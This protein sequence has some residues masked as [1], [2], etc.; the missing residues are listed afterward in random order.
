MINFSWYNFNA[1]ISGGIKKRMHECEK[2]EKK[3]GNLDGAKE[4]CE[5]LDYEKEKT[6]EIMRVFKEL[7]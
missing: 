7:R 6:E 4:H 3:K 2:N 5:S 1:G